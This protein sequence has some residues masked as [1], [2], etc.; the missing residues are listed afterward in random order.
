MRILLA[1]E[2]FHP[3]VGGV[4]EVMRQIGERFAQRGHEVVV[5]TTYLPER[6]SSNVAGMAVE[7]FRIS[8]NLVAGML[9]DVERYRDFVLR[10]DYDV[11]LVK[12]VQQWTFDALIPVLGDIRKPKVLIP[13]GFSALFDPRY[14]DYYRMMPVWLRQF[15]RLIFYASKYRDIDMARAHG[16]TNI[17][18]VPN[19]ADGREFNTRKDSTFRSRYGIPE[20]AFLVM[21][22]G[23]LTGLKGHAELAAAFEKCHFGD[24]NACLLLIGDTPRSRPDWRVDWRQVYRLGG[25]VRVAK[26]MWRLVLEKSRLHSLLGLFGYGPS[27]YA[28][29]E[30]TVRRALS[31]I[32]RRSNRKAVCLNLPRQ[33]VIQAYLNSDLFVLAS[34]IEYSPLVL[35]EAAAAGL[36][37]LSVPVGNA[38]EIVEWTQGGV[39]CEAAVDSNGY[40]EVDVG[41]LARHIDVLAAQPAERARLGANAR[42]SWEGRFTWDTI[43]HAYEKIF[44]ECL[45]KAPA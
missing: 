39:I 31:S 16:L 24:R 23:S 21:T 42:Q 37:F 11:L 18:I 8:G 43:F 13:C 38:E 15:D 41:E 1:C 40:T 34:K 22:V 26:W 33:E 29:A 2:L 10:Q 32:N 17:S 9:G 4:Q 19:G 7:A 44:D 45:Q 20:D 27:V 5:A 35:F 12:A 30:R 3:S 6:T 28:R 36:P 25:A 14:A